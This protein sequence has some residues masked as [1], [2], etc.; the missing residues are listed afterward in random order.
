MRI[1]G[2]GA[3]RAVA[4]DVR[5]SPDI[6]ACACL[7]RLRAPTQ[8]DALHR[9]A[10]MYRTALSDISIVF[11]WLVWVSWRQVFPVQVEI[12]GSGLAESRIGYEAFRLQYYS[13]FLG[14]GRLA[15][16]ILFVCLAVVIFAADITPVILKREGSVRQH[17]S[18]YAPP[19]CLNGTAWASNCRSAPLWR[20]VFVQAELP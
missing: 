1:R 19:P 18:R 6:Q 15:V 3:R 5:S 12:H 11:V 7:C 14:W 17:W 9:P 10:Y 13:H 2:L 4:G 20:C 8:D 16:E